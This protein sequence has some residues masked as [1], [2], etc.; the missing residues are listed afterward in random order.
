MDYPKLNT[1]A[2]RIMTSIERQLIYDWLKLEGEKDPVIIFDFLKACDDFE[3]TRDF[4]LDRA[5][6]FLNELA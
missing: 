5:R 6:K 3:D 1:K 2:T 4:C